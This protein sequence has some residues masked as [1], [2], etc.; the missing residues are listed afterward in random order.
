MTKRM[1][2]LLPLCGILIALGASLWAQKG[3]A[4]KTQKELDA[5]KAWQAATDPDERIKGHRECAHQLCGHR[6]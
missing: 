2:Y 5:L 1:N 4:P 6:V 3:P